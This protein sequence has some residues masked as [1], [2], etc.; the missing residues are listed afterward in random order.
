[1]A[2]ISLPTCYN[3]SW[4]KVPE[5]FYTKLGEFSTSEDVGADASGNRFTITGLVSGSVYW[6]QVTSSDAEGST[7]NTISLSGLTA[8]E[9]STSYYHDTYSALLTGFYKVSGDPVV[10]ITSGSSHLNNGVIS[11]LIIEA[12]IS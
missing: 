7:A 4:S 3:C 9:G 1:M 8:V 6:L 12:D 11:V 10:T 2:P 5:A